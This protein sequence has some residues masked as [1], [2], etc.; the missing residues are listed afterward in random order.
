LKE[1]TPGQSHAHLEINL[2]VPKHKKP[3]HLIPPENLNLKR[4]TQAAY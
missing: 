4:E 2:F 3:I 1:L